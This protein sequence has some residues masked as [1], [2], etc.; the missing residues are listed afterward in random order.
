L[1]EAI[2]YVV[3][4]FGQQALVEQ[5]VYGREFCVGLLGN[6]DPEAFPI[7]EIDL[8]NDPEAVQ[9]EFDK[10]NSPRGKI[11]PAD[12]AADIGSRMVALSKQSFN[13]LGLK[14]FARVDIRM[15][16]NYD[17]HILEINSMASLGLRSSYVHAA[18]VAGY[19][20]TKLVNKMLDVAAVRYFSESLQVENG[21][22][23][24]KTKAPL[25]VRLRGFLRNTTDKSER[26]LA[27]MV[28]INSYVRNLDGVN[29][30]GMLIIKW[31]KPLG[32]K[33]QVIPQVEVGNVLIL[34]NT[35]DPP[36]VLL[37]GNIDNATPFTKHIHYRETAHKLYGTAIWNSKGGLAV[38]LA[39]LR[40]LR[41]VRLLR[42]MK[43]NILLT[44]D[45]T[46]QNNITKNTIE[47]LSS[48]ARIVVGLSG[49]SLTGSV[50]TSRSGAA[51]Y[52]CQMNLE[53]AQHT[54]DVAEA[55]AAFNNLLASIA[56]LT[57]KAD[58]ILVAL[59]DVSMKSGISP[60]Y[61]HGEGSFSVRF[62]DIH[63]AEMIAHRIQQTVKK[64]KCPKCR[65]QISGGVRRPP[66][67]YTQEVQNLY[68]LLKDIC[69]KLDVRVVEE[70]R[71]SSSDICFAESA[72]RRIDGLGPI[73]S[74]P[75]DDEEYIL[76]HSLL[77]RAILLAM[78]LETL[79]REKT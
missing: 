38:M 55:S 68:H 56:K 40:A 76:R 54:E 39:A 33:A 20:Y 17:I 1:R 21:A 47:E 46:L 31:L 59:R 35:D 32:F 71:W 19:D 63:H 57:R 34:R 43:V 2:K 23:H 73:G 66:M 49:A 8:G 22:I 79:H 28:N 4:E 69:G 50:I 30:L 78:L 11:C 29:T 12:I 51:V 7:V 13:I 52:N 9:N 6:G 45:S 60:L 41:F 24:L 25:S 18:K 70:H 64:A 16:R 48:K 36:D 62:N 65:F 42:K 72:E 27:R 5:F 14:D 15:D 53:N 10:L 58:H 77:D 61:A 44:T 67:I 75:H 74:A 3:S 26:S 37:L